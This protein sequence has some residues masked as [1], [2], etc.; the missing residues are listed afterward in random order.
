MEHKSTKNYILNK[1]NESEEDDITT[2]AQ[3]V[4][5]QLCNE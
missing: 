4:Q 3:K 5:C 2:C 1:E